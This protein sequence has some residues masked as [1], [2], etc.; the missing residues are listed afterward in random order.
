MERDSDTAAVDALGVVA[1]VSGGMRAR[2]GL[3]RCCD[4]PEN[5]EQRYRPHD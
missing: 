3:K 4:C 5:H 2:R 1:V